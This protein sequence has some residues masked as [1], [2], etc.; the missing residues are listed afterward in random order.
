M[1]VCMYHNIFVFTLDR[2]Y[3]SLI[4]FSQTVVRAFVDHFTLISLTLAYMYAN[5][6][7]IYSCYN[8]NNVILIM[9]TFDTENICLYIILNKCFKYEIPPAI[10]FVFGLLRHRGGVAEFLLHLRAIK[11]KNCHQIQWLYIV[12]IP[13][14][15]VH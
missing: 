13:D 15:G 14:L 1:Y 5:I 3:T 6:L 8:H 7:R 4:S 11:R 10:S 9:N 12:Y 2:S